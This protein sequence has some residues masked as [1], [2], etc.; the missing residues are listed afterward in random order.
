M[1]SIILHPNATPIYGFLSFI[2]YQNKE[3]PYSGKILDCGAGGPIP[4][5]ALF[6][7]QGFE[8]WGVDISEEQLDKARH[9]CQEQNI[10]IHLQE[11]DMRHI[12]FDNESF[13]YVYEH[14]SMCHLNKGDT[15]AAISEMRRVLRPQGLCFLGVISTDTWPKLLFGEER[16]PGEY[17]GEEDGKQNVLHSMFNDEE[18]DILV[19][20]WEVLIKEKQVRYLQDDAA[21]LSLEEWM[22]LLPEA[23]KKNSES[24]WRNRY[25]RRSMDYQYVHLYYLLKKKEA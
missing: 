23:K 25:P 20:G 22:E 16:K 24:D 7:K 2:R 8:S 4:P 14:F 3:T 17:W 13:D 9:F 19:S 18:A 12:P 15:L 1:E 6:Q 10:D 11:G 5:L 21:K